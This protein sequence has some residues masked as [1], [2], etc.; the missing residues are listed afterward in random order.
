[1]YT[2]LLVPLDG[3]ATARLAL[4]HAATLARLSGATIV[5]LHIID[6]MD[7]SNGFERPQVYLDEVRPRFLAAG[8][9]LLDEAASQ[10]R[11]ENIPVETVL[12]ETRGEPVAGL[13]AQ[14]ATATGSG[15]VIMGTH[16]RRGMNRLLLGSDAEQVARI[17][18]VPVMLVRHAHASTM[19]TR[20]TEIVPDAVAG[21]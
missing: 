12:L 9:A 11:K 6:G 4:E 21:E 5:L 20:S 8:R 10:L 2:R 13:I 19:D 14:Q 15:L 7:H 17:A 16:G 18:P 1:M 3:S